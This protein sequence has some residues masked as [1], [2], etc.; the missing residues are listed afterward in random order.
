MHLEMR[1]RRRQLIQFQRDVREVAA[2]VIVNVCDLDR[3]PG[4]CRNENLR[5]HHNAVSDDTLQ[6]I[7]G[8]A[9]L[10]DAVIQTDAKIGA[11]RQ[12]HRNGRVFRIEMGGGS[13]G[14][15]VDNP[16]AQ[17]N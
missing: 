10:R 12:D 6:C 16:E 14:G 1:I 11:R 17:H 4:I 7:T 3:C 15:P 2:T 5:V 9:T 8:F 13:V